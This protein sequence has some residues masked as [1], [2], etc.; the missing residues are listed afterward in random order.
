MVEE[1]DL[2]RNIDRRSGS[3]RVWAD[4]GHLLSRLRLMV[5]L[6]LS[7]SYLGKED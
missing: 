6:L 1:R 7:Y 5:S 4:D 2:S 3:G